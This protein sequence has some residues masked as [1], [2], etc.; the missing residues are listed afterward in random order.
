MNLIFY[1]PPCPI[2]L[3]QSIYWE[4]PLTND[5]KPQCFQAASAS[6][7]SK[8][9]SYVIIKPE[10]LSEM[11]M[12]RAGVWHGRY[13]ERNKLIFQSIAL[14][15]WNLCIYSR[16]ILWKTGHLKQLTGQCDP[17]KTWR[18]N[19]I[20]FGPAQRE[21][22]SKFHPPLYLSPGPISFR[23]PYKGPL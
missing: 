13:E 3:T 9:L 19:A 6:L 14:P 17:D 11:V 21:I 8:S 1:L 22:L 2:C 15:L 20:I 23:R 12:K 5:K 18:A 7:L 16:L 10:N 4:L